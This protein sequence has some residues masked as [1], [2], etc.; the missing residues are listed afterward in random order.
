MFR[1]AIHPSQLKRNLV[2]DRALEKQVSW[3]WEASTNESDPTG[4]ASFV[5]DGVES[6]RIK[7]LNVYHV[8]L[9]ARLIDLAY[10]QGRREG[11]KHI[12]EV[13]GSEIRKLC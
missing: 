11:L 3:K 4:F 1:Q 9:I 7:L 2:I 5:V 10:Q 8:K 12:S 6:E 13:I